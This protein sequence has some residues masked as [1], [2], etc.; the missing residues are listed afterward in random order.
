MKNNLYY[1]KIHITKFL[2]CKKYG[3]SSYLFRTFY[4]TFLPHLLSHNLY[5]FIF[6][7]LPSSPVSASPAVS[8]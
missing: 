6:Y 1:E 8:S 4:F 2:K 5:F 7:F 3:D